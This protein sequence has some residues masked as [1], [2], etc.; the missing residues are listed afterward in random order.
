MFATF[1]DLDLFRMK[2]IILKDPK[3]QSWLKILY[4]KE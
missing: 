3:P 1:N 2:E 4:K